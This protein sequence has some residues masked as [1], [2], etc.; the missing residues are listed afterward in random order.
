M[1]FR[2][3]IDQF[4]IQKNKDG[5]PDPT[6]SG[7][8]P[9]PASAG[10]AGG[11]PASA[12]APVSTVSKAE[13]DRVLSELHGFKNQAKELLDAK[14]KSEEENLRANKQWKEL[15][16]RHEKT[17][18]D[19]QEKFSGLSQSVVKDKKISAVREAA[20]K[21]GIRQEALQ[22]LEMLELRDVQVETTST[23][24]INV[25]GAE[26]AISNLKT[27]RPHWFGG[28]SGPGVNTNTPGVTG[29][30]TPGT[31][32][33]QQVITAEKEA[34]KTGDSTAYIRLFKAYQAQQKRA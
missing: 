28:S 17:A 22:D 31:V 1:L 32:T 4:V 11:A 33:I 27:L 8:A 26:T 15:A 25:L 34:K 5:A 29:N 23:G 16:E 24:R 18:K 13:F 14:N 19:W 2:N 9:D 7:G 20:L 30:G 12:P 10:G 6:A 21:S 3:N